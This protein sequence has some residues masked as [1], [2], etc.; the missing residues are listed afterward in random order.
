MDAH[1]KSAKVITTTQTKWTK[2]VS[3][4]DN[5]VNDQNKDNHYSTLVK[6][7]VGSTQHFSLSCS[8]PL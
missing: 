7:V 2:L 3:I 1:I 8:W 6:H 4:Y 5:L